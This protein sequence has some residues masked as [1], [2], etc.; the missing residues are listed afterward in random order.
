MP[1]LDSVRAHDRIPSNHS[2]NQKCRRVQARA[3]CAPPPGPDRAPAPSAQIPFPWRWRR[4]PASRRFP[5][6]RSCQPVRS[7][8]ARSWGLVVAPARS[9]GL[10]YSNPLECTYRTRS[11]LTSKVGELPDFQSASSSECASHRRLISP[12]KPARLARPVALK[13]ENVLN[14]AV[15][16]LR[17]EMITVAHIDEL[18]GH[19][20]LVAYFAH[21]S[22]QHRPH[23]QLIADF[24]KDVLFVLALECKTGCSSRHAQSRHLGQHIDQFLGHPVT[25]ILVV[26]V[27]AHVHERQHRDRFVRRM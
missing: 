23:V 6:K 14:V 9:N 13:V 7:R 2:A 21:A 20:Q 18:C 17:P 24:T 16:I 22:F 4:F 8:R 1:D 15:V 19:T 3:T 12:A 10:H 11:G 25:Q 5:C 26:F 27:R